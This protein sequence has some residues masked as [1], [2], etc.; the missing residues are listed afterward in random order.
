MLRRRPPTQQRLR[1]RAWQRPGRLLE[2][3]QERLKRNNGAARPPLTMSNAG[4]KNAGRTGLVQFISKAR[5]GLKNA[6]VC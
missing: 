6:G 4:L 2:K 3:T 5:F 1:R